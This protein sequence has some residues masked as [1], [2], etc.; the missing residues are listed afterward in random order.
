[1]GSRTGPRESGSWYSA[2]GDRGG[3]EVLP[4]LS[5]EGGKLAGG[6]AQGVTEAGSCESRGSFRQKWWRRMRCS[7]W[8]KHGEVA[9]A[10]GW[11]GR[12]SGLLHSAATPPAT[13]GS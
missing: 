4:R 13:L 12:V 8:G 6:A 11:P 2:L 5:G 3:W 7:R 9:N 1:M 10:S